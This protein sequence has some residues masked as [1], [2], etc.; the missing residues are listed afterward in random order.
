M[1]LFKISFIVG[2]MV[3]VHFAYTSPATLVSETERI[4]EPL[5]T[6][7]WVRCLEGGKHVTGV[8]CFVKLK[9]VAFM[10]LGGLSH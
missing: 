10:A 7:I 3:G 4:S 2:A 6:L 1:S 5:R 8:T 9:R